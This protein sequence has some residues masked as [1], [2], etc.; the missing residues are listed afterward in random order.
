MFL[1][2]F[3]HAHAR[4]CSCSCPSSSICKISATTVFA[5]TQAESGLARWLCFFIKDDPDAKLHYCKLSIAIRVTAKV[6]ICK[7]QAVRCIARGAPA[8]N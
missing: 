8:G 5:C 6:A 1:L 4:V 3:A 7:G 2:A